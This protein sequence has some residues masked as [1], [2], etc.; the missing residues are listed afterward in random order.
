MTASGYIVG[1][2]YTNTICFNVTTAS[3]HHWASMWAP[4]V[5]GNCIADSNY[6]LAFY[7]HVT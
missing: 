4:A 6:W 3:C 7:K 5:A 1:S 2:A